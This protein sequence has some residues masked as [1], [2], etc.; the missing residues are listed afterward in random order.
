MSGFGATTKELAG[1][2]SFPSGPFFDYP[3][4]TIA[5]SSKNPQPSMDQASLFEMKKLSQEIRQIGKQIDMLLQNNELNSDHFSTLKKEQKTLSALMN[6]AAAYLQKG[7]SSI[8]DNILDKILNGGL[9][10]NEMEVPKAPLAAEEDLEDVTDVAAKK[11]QNVEITNANA[12]RNRLIKSRRALYLLVKQAKNAQNSRSKV[13]STVFPRSRRFAIRM[14]LPQQLVVQAIRTLIR[15]MSENSSILSSPTQILLFKV[16]AKL[17]VHGCRNP[18]SFKQIMESIENTQKLL[19]VVLENAGHYEYVRHAMLCFILDVVETEGPCVDL[20]PLAEENGFR[21]SPNVESKSSLSKMDDDEDSISAQEGM[22]VNNSDSQFEFLAK[23]KR[24]KENPS[25]MEELEEKEMSPMEEETVGSAST[26]TFTTNIDEDD[27]I[28]IIADELAKPTENGVALENPIMSPTLAVSGLLPDQQVP[29]MMALGENEMIHPGLLDERL[30]IGETPAYPF[31]FTLFDKPSE[32]DVDMLIIMALLALRPIEMKNPPPYWENYRS[33]FIRQIG[34]AVCRAR[35]DS[36]EPLSDL[37][38]WL[39]FVLGAELEAANNC[40]TEGAYVRWGTLAIIHAKDFI[41]REFGMSGKLT[42]QSEKSPSHSALACAGYFGQYYSIYE[43]TGGNNEFDDDNTFLYLDEN[44]DDVFRRLVEMA[45]RP[46]DDSESLICDL[47]TTLERKRSAGK[48]DVTDQPEQMTELTMLCDN[49][50]NNYLTIDASEDAVHF[51]AIRGCMPLHKAIFTF[52]KLRFMQSL[53]QVRRFVRGLPFSQLPE[54]DEVK[55]EKKKNTRAKFSSPSLIVQRKT[56]SIT[57]VVE[58]TRSKEKE[59]L[60]DEILYNVAMNA[61][62]YNSRACPISL[63]VSALISS[64]MSLRMNNNQRRQQAE[65][66]VSEC[67]HRTLQRSLQRTVKI[68]AYYDTR[69]QPS[70]ESCS[71]FVVQALNELIFEMDPQKANQMPAR[72]NRNGSGLFLQNLLTFFWDFQGNVIAHRT[73][74]AVDPTHNAATF[75]LNEKTIANLMHFAAT[76][77]YMNELTWGQ[78]LRALNTVD[79]PVDVV[80]DTKS[81]KFT[82]WIENSPYFSD[83]L[84]RFFDSSVGRFHQ[85]SSTKPTFGPAVA[86]VFSRFLII[87]FKQMSSNAMDILLSVITE[88]IRRSRSTGYVDFPLEMLSEVTALLDKMDRVCQCNPSILADFMTAVLEFVSDFFVEFQRMQ[89]HF[90]DS[91]P[92]YGLSSFIANDATQIPSNVCFSVVLSTSHQ[93]DRNAMMNDRWR[94]F[95]NGNSNTKPTKNINVVKRADIL[96]NAVR[97]G[98]VNANDQFV[99]LIY[100]FLRF[101]VRY[102]SQYRPQVLKA[103]LNEQP[104]TLNLAIDTLFMFISC[105]NHVD[106]ITVENFK[107]VTLADAVVHLLLVIS[108]NTMEDPEIC[109]QFIRLVIKVL[110]SRV[111]S[112][113]DSD[114]AGP[115]TAADVNQA[116]DAQETT[117]MDLPVPVLLLMKSLLRGVSRCQIFVEE[118][119][120]T[121]ISEQLQLALDSCSQD[122][123]ANT[124][125]PMMSRQLTALA[126][127]ITGVE[128]SNPLLNTAVPAA[129]Q[130]PS[131]TQTGPS[132]SSSRYNS[133]TQSIGQSSTSLLG[134]AN[135]NAN[136]PQN[137]SNQSPPFA[138]TCPSVSYQPSNNQSNPRPFSAHLAHSHYLQMPPMTKSFLRPSIVELDEIFNFSPVATFRSDSIAPSQLS[139][140][141]TGH[142]DYS[143]RSRNSTFT[144]KF[145][146]K[147]Q[148]VDVTM[149]LP[150]KIVLYEVVIQMPEKSEA[151]SPSSIQIELSSDSMQANW[152]VLS[153]PVISDNITHYRISTHSYRFPV[154]GVRINFQCPTAT[155]TMC[156]SQIQLLG[157]TS[158]RAMRYLGNSKMFETQLMNHW[159]SLFARLCSR[160]DLPSWECAPSLSASLIKVYLGEENSTEMFR[161]IYEL[162]LQLDRKSK[163]LDSSLVLVIVDYLLSG[164]RICSRA[165]LSLAELLY[166]SCALPTASSTHQQRFGLDNRPVHVAHSTAVNRQR[167]LLNGIK[168]LLTNLLPQ[169]NL[170]SEDSNWTRPEALKE[171]S[172]FLWSAACVIWHNT[173]DDSI[174]YDTMAICFDVGSVVILYLAHFVLNIRE[175]NLLHA[176]SWM[177][178]ALARSSPKHL[179]SIFEK[180]GLAQ[181]AAVD[182]S[183]T[184][185]KALGKICQSATAVRYLMSRNLL[186]DWAKIAIEICDQEQ[187]HRL[188][189][190]VSIV[191]CFNQL[192]VIDIVAK[193]FEDYENCPLFPKLLHYIRKYCAS[194]SRHIEQI[195]NVAPSSR[196][197]E[198]TISL[199]RRCLA[200]GGQHR[201]KVAHLVCDLLKSTYTNNQKGVN[202]PETFEDIVL[203]LIVADETITVRLTG[204]VNKRTETHQGLEGRMHHPLFGCNQDDRIM[205]IPLSTYCKDL[206]PYKPKP[207]PVKTRPMDDFILGSQLKLVFASDEVEDKEAAPPADNRPPPIDQPPVQNYPYTYNQFALQLVCAAYSTKHALNNEWSLEKIVDGL[208]A[209]GRFNHR[210]T[211]SVSFL[212][213]CLR[214][215]EDEQMSIATDEP[216][217]IEVNDELSRTSMAFDSPR[218]MTTPEHVGGNRPSKSWQSP[219]MTPRTHSR[220][221]LSVDPKAFADEGD[222]TDGYFTLTLRVKASLQTN[223]MNAVEDESMLAEFLKNLQP[224]SSTLFEFAHFGGL[225]LLAQS[226]DILSRVDAKLQ[227]L[228]GMM[229]QLSEAQYGVIKREIANA[230]RSLAKSPLKSNGIGNTPGTSQL[231]DPYSSLYQAM[232]EPILKVYNAFQM[233]QERGVQLENT[234]K[235]TQS[236]GHGAQAKS[237]NYSTAAFA[238]LQYEP[239]IFD[240]M[241]TMTMTAADEEELMSMVDFMNSGEVFVSSPNKPPKTS[242]QVYSYVASID[243]EWPT[244]T[245]SILAG[246]NF[247]PV[248][249]AS[250]YLPPPSTLVVGGDSVSKSEI[251]GQLSSQLT[252]FANKF[253]NLQSSVQE[254]LGTYVLKLPVTLPLKRFQTARSTASSTATD[255]NLEYVLVALSLFLEIE[256]YGE[257]LVTYDKTSAKKL[258]YLMLGMDSPATPKQRLVDGLQP[259]L[260]Q[261]LLGGL[262]GDLHSSCNEIER[263]EIVRTIAG[264]LTDR[265]SSLDVSNRN[266]SE[267]ERLMLVPFLVLSSCFEHLHPRKHNQLEAEKVRL[268]A[269][270]NGTMDVILTLLSYFG[271]QKPAKTPI[272]ATGELVVTQLVTRLISLTSDIQS[273]FGLFNAIGGKPTHRRASTAALGNSAA[274]GSGTQNTQ[275]SSSNPN[276]MGF[277]NAANFANHNTANSNDGQFWAKGTGFGSGSTSVHWNLANHVA[278]RKQHEVTVTCLLNILTNYVKRQTVAATSRLV[279]SF[280]RD[281]SDTKNGQKKHQLAKLAS[282]HDEPSPF[283]A[284]PGRFVQMV[285]RSCLNSILNSYIMNDSVLDISRHVMVYESVVGLILS[286]CSSVSVAREDEQTNIEHMSDLILEADANSGF[287]IYMSKLRKSASS[288]NDPNGHQEENLGDLLEVAQQAI[289]VMVQRDEIRRDQNRDRFGPD[290]NEEQMEEQ[291]QITILD[292]NGY[293]TGQPLEVVYNNLMRPLQFESIAFFASDGVTPLFPYLYS[294]NLASSSHGVVA[295]RTRRLAQEIVTLSTSLPLSMSSSVFLRTADERLDV[296]KV[297]ITG[298]VDTPYS[299][300]CFEFDVAFPEN[301]PSTPMNMNLQVSFFKSIDSSIRCFRRLEIEPYVLTP[302]F[303]VSI[304]IFFDQQPR[305]SEEG[306]VCLSILN[307]WSGRPEERWNAETSS[308]LQV[309]VSI[310][311]LIFVNEPIQLRI[312]YSY[313]NEPGFERSRGT[314]AGD[315]SSRD[316]TANIRHQCIRWAMLDMLRKPPPAFAKVVRRHFWLKRDEICLQIHEWIRETREFVEKNSMVKSMPQHLVLLEKNFTHLLNEFHKMECPSPDLAHI[317]SKYVKDYF[318]QK[319]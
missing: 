230:R 192:A 293:T 318:A 290:E 196:L 268:Y 212:E 62:F 280:D 1:F 58:K 43:N 6:T 50:E 105:T 127:H 42:A 286:F 198:S 103:L 80:K 111:N 263:E 262:S 55:P 256:S 27:A 218:P 180:L 220:T 274:P 259:L 309:L 133:A 17:A 295:K 174:R 303:T 283:T 249:S 240:S 148:W 93:R 34:Y 277:S 181:L 75:V 275:T 102:V 92:T 47:Q 312:P 156:L 165:Y 238:A 239:A 208:R 106:D 123:L 82:Q 94:A 299:G 253:Q 95:N 101:S 91:I 57:P 194:S 28:T 201:T 223:I 166:A 216:M 271:H 86:N 132:S 12:I 184:V 152:T 264:R 244:N 38:R 255:Q 261:S 301:Y 189:Q 160:I 121:F 13:N 135:F 186:N 235:P 233:L 56:S 214:D 114:I 107:I 73:Q 32:S 128:P 155:P 134:P 113:P 163:A 150:Y 87:V 195:S 131:N 254:S 308:F 69:T 224:L 154:T 85:I 229:T 298:P 217:D 137:S 219:I 23:A 104:K 158:V 130:Q 98:E 319:Q 202:L 67:L 10:K 51:V 200:F 20:S 270:E 310:Q 177:L 74:N 22:K 231:N 172:I 247:N 164:G 188:P 289:A 170:T 45:H 284:I 178:C 279:A 183:V 159:V 291:R 248:S 241:E 287:S 96:E 118:G 294:G 138:L 146:P 4:N 176:S 30:T 25:E 124:R 136:N 31:A 222:Y 272:R 40:K 296:M 315:Q 109:R 199:I 90:P 66:L 63:G 14:Q 292:E 100:S 227:I 281:N 81:Y 147:K 149:V 122:W 78:L 19:A 79:S 269:L 9:D 168:D 11:Q 191:D 125:F 225:K 302:T 29:E 215:D 306:K 276:Y 7:M 317:E 205:E 285:E 24:R 77:E 316:Y 161:T 250:L 197:V 169:E 89:R 204:V 8:H 171:I 251:F 97:D 83:L 242:G 151:N 52:S 190:L 68:S 2:G 72:T 187:H 266:D 116:G 237:N 145:M 112:K 18:L 193:Y 173:S 213:K 144:Y 44:F 36:G 265:L 61:Y 140:L 126:S 297:L 60:S 273:I 175:P 108:E 153:C 167:H 88:K 129:I 5:S 203:R 99:S 206:L 142:Q 54:P 162:L 39:D 119:G 228:A 313:F 21:E 245:P 110:R 288:T 300:G 211:D 221:S 53:I 207:T 117:L 234:D 65:R 3:P 246:S 46:S 26:S 16:C 76:Y 120:H 59:A 304:R 71:A 48:M 232:E 185:M 260:P 257:M 267:M 49:V 179:D 307:T 15:L 139:V 311:S 35:F 282:T 84:R 209:I 236:T 278:K 157:A 210:H 115:S 314:P 182:Y 252:E 41:E 226:V 141:T 243:D 70:M 64:T 143:K 305:I 258:I 33:W 37:F